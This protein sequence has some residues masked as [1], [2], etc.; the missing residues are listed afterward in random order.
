M[1]ASGRVLVAEDNAAL[2]RVVQFNLKKAGY[3]AV[4]APDGRIAWQYANSEQFDAIVTDQ[5][6]PEMTGLELCRAVR[7]LP[8]YADLPIVMLTAKG[9]ELELPRL[10]DELNISETFSKPFS[11]AKVVSKV[12]EL[13]AQSAVAN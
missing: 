1:T 3:D 8:N 6:M 2:A 10:R 4:V 11:P 5:Q 9:L 12:K 7:E 13:I